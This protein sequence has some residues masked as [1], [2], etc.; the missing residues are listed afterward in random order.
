MSNRAAAAREIDFCFDSF[1]EA[2]DA[3]LAAGG[4][5]RRV[6]EWM[7]AK[8]D[9]IHQRISPETGVVWISAENTLKMSRNAFCDVDRGIE[10]AAPSTIALQ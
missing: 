8:I 4:D 1:A 5:P 2:I 7:V 6:L 10:H 9:C 3:Y